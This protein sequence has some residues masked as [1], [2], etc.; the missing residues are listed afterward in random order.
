MSYLRRNMGITHTSSQEGQRKK[1]LKGTPK[2]RKKVTKST[3]SSIVPIEDEAPTR[4]MTFPP[5]QNLE[6]EPTASKKRKGAASNSR[7]TGS[8]ISSEIT[9]RKKGM[10]GSSNFGASK[11]SRSGSNQPE[12]LS[13]GLPSSKDK[14][15][16]VVVKLK[17]KRRKKEVDKNAA[18]NLLSQLDSPAMGTRSKRLQPS[19]PALST[20][21]KRRMCL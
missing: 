20:R 2:K 11:R 12:P 17:G 6:P 15:Q 9:S 14:P 18:K 8:S 3:E 1:I 21:S 19:S 13:I 5:S 10:Q 4:S 7:P 16:A